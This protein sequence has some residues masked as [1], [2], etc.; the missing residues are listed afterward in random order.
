MP[1]VTE[2]MDVI[3]DYAGAA[4]D[5]AAI[6]ILIALIPDPD[7]VANGG[8]GAIADSANNGVNNTYLDEMSPV[9]AAVL[10]NELAALKA[11]VIA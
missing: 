7:T 3:G 2:G 4:D 11:A 1:N 8:S 10:L 6:D 5:G 9:A